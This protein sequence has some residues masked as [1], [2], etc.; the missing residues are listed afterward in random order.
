VD[1][2]A[3]S[4]RACGPAPPDATAARRAPWPFRSR[5]EERLATEPF[6]REHPFVA[7]VDDLLA[8]IFAGL[9]TRQRLPAS[10]RGLRT[11]A[12]TRRTLTQLEAELVSS[13]RRDGATWREI[14]ADLAVSRTTVHA[15]HAAASKSARGLRGPGNGE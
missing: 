5:P 14:A 13:A 9:P 12:A 4:G 10:R 15:R 3:E 6:G 11:L 2:T 7:E 8:A 1:T